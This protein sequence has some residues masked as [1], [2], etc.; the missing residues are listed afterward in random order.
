[1]CGLT[2]VRTYLV[3]LVVITKGLFDDHLV[4]IEAVLK[5]L[6]RA[7][8]CVNAPTCGFDLHEIEYLGYLLVREGIKLQ[9]EKASAIHISHLSTEEHK[10][11]M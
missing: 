4:K 3:D 1:M 2:Y 9:P 7:K 11:T 10:I 6:R 5:Q 8:L